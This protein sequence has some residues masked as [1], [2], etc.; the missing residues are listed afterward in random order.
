MYSKEMGFGCYPLFIYCCFLIHFHPCCDVGWQLNIQTNQRQQSWIHPS[1]LTG[2]EIP[3]FI[4]EFFPIH[5][6]LSF[7]ILRVQKHTHIAATML[8]VLCS[9]W[10]WSSGLLVAWEQIICKWHRCDRPSDRV[11]FSLVAPMG[12]SLLSFA[13]IPAKL[14]NCEHRELSAPSFC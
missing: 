4:S 5:I 10:Q 14:V 1:H 13:T 12:G 7:F 2:R 9:L 6:L 8:T 3:I 11:V